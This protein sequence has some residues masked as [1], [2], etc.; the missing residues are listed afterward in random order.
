[1]DKLVLDSKLPGDL[2]DLI[3]AFKPRD[4][5]MKS[6]TAA[7]VKAMM[8]FFEGKEHPFFSGP[9]GSHGMLRVGG[10]VMLTCFNLD[11]ILRATGI[12]T[13]F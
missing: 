4:R 13:S 9:C 7:L 6:P 1:M 12:S 11:N 10:L 2:V 5:D 3:M 8:G